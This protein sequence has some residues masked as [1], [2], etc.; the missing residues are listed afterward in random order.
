MNANSGLVR[1]HDTQKTIIA[2]Y[3]Y[4]LSNRNLN[5][6]TRGIFLDVEGAFDAITH[7]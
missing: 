3:A 6:D 7:F 1:G 4:D 2:H 5:M